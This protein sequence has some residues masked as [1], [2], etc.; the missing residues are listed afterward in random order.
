[1]KILYALVTALIFGAPLAGCD[2]DE[3]PLEE[4]AEE[5]EEAGE[6]AGDEVEDATD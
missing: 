5:V 1:M 3:G 2:R 6:E 4:S